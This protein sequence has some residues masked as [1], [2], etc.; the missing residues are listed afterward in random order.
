M[1]VENGFEEHDLRRALLD[2]ALYHG[3]VAEMILYEGIGMIFVEQ[4]DGR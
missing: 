2:Q 1:C 3:Q 4:G